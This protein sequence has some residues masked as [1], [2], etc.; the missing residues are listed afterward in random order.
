VPEVFESGVAVTVTVQLA[1]APR[2]EPHAFVSANH[3]AWPP[4]MVTEVIDIV[5]VPVFETVT[6]CG[7]L[8]LFCATVPKFRELT[9]SVNTGS[10]PAPV[11]DTATGPPR[12]LVL[13]VRVLKRAPAT[14]GSNFRVTAQL[15]L[16]ASVAPQV[17]AV[18]R[19]STPSVCVMLLMVMVAL[20]LFCRVTFWEALVIPTFS[21]PKAS[22]V[23]ERLAI[24]AR[25][26]PVKLADCVPGEAV[27]VTVRVAVRLP[28]PLGVKD[29]V[30]VQTA[31]APRVF[32]QLLVWP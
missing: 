9:E 4:V 6:L 8:V 30:I 25:P 19:K 20:P 21:L 14:V 7:E 5:P 29:M 16:T 22:E 12:A 27:S 15:A 32:P 2:V 10:V 17:F 18:I 24:E 26:T 1:P 13:N 11:R 28:S 3:A 23:A 31:P